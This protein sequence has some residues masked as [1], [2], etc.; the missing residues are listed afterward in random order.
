MCPL[1]T[2]QKHSETNLRSQFGPIYFAVADS[3]HES[4]YDILPVGSARANSVLFR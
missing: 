1:V 2:P 4:V 3:F